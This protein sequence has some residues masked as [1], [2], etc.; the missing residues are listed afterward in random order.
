MIIDTISFAERYFALHPGL[1]VAFAFLRSTPLA[2]M[3]EGRHAIDGSRLSVI[4][5]RAVGR[6]RHGAKLEVH[7]RHLD[8]QL[9]LAGDELIGWRPLTDCADAESQFNAERDIQFFRD[10]P[11]TWLA[12]RPGLFA[13][14][15]PDDAHAPLAGEGPVHKVV[16][17]L[18]VDWHA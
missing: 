10:Q 18:A 4:V 9:C 11:E 2:E 16:F 14:F 3:P 13:I 7:R 17:K 5:E 6:G 15:F 12:V 8:I 1:S